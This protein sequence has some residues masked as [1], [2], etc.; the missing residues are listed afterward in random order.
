M[1]K[2]VSVIVGYLVMA[3]FT[4]VTG[5]VAW[6][7]LGAEFAFDPGTTVVTPGWLALNFLF[8]ITGA[9]I[10]GFICAK[11]GKSARTVNV[12]AVIIFL[13]A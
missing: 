3:L 7:G 5:A 10:G 12:F 9:I 11:M 8:G 2:A 13:F 4:M 1:K 6:F